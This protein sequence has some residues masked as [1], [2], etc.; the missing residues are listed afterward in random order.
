MVHYLLDGEVVEGKYDKL[1]SQELFYRVNKIQ[2]AY[3]L[4]LFGRENER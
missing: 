2:A 1:I 4:G 3:N